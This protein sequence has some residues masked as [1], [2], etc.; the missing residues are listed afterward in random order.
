MLTTAIVV[1]GLQVDKTTLRHTIGVVTFPQGMPLPFIEFPF[2]PHVDLP[3]LNSVVLVD[4]NDY[5]SAYICKVADPN[6]N[7]TRTTLGL[8]TGQTF[9]EA[10]EMQIA[11]GSG[12]AIFLNNNGGIRLTTGNVKEEISLDNNEIDIHG[13]TID[14]HAVPTL[15]TLQG[16]MTLD[17]SSN[18]TMG[19]RN[20]LTQLSLTTLAFDIL[21]NIKI[22]NTLTLSSITM[23]PLGNITLTSPIS[24]SINAPQATVTAPTTTVNATTVNLNAATVNSGGPGGQKLATESFVKLIYDLHVHTSATPGNPTSPPL[25]PGESLPL[26]LTTVTKAL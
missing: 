26:A 25:I 7:F 6:N 21:G 17:S 16:F 4:V 10:G 18:A 19:I 23:D 22:S 2:N 14:I 12:A 3:P 11:V 20:P 24:V 9:I 13:T 8:Q 1:T 15:P 5:Q